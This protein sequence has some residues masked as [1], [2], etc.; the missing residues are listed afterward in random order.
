MAAINNTNT[1]VTEVTDATTRSPERLPRRLR[2]R[3][4]EVRTGRRHTPQRAQ[5]SPGRQ[6][7]RQQVRRKQVGQLRAYNSEIHTFERAANTVNALEPFNV[8][9]L[10][11]IQT[12]R[13]LVAELLR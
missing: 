2:P 7:R 9:L 4:N 5:A 12:K 10:S 1:K 6:I 13:S 8:C 3:L 11:A